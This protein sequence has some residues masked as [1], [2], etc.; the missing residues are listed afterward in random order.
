MSRFSTIANLDESPLVEGLIYVGTDDG[1]IQVTEDGGETWREID[2][3][4]G[5]PDYFYVNDI[6]ADLHDPDT[7][8]V[9]VDNHKAGDFRPYILKSTNRGRNW[10][11]IA[12]DLPD[13][14]IV[15]RVI[16]DHV[17]PDLLFAAT[18][19]G[20]FFTADGG[21][22]WT[23]LDGGLP[24]ISFRDL[25]IQKREN[26]L[27]A[28][29]FGRSFYVLDDY[30]PLREATPELFSDSEFHI[31][32]VRRAFWYVQDNELGGEKGYQGDSLFN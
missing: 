31:F 2:S 23:E 6:K 30:S 10:R 5:V 17:D 11:S 25:E 18:E 8:Y 27:V 1:L 3:L 4:P 20:L 15:W 19:L 21:G 14:H 24:T 32:P 13:R 9:A 28:A 26:D 7:V 22:N 16:Q 12:D 29:S